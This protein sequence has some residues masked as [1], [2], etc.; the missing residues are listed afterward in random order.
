MGARLTFSEG[1]IERRER[2]INC[3]TSIHKDLFITRKN[4]NLLPFSE[5]IALLGIY[6]L[7]WELQSLFCALRTTRHGPTIS[8]RIY[9]RP[10]RGDFHNEFVNRHR[11]E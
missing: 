6:C 8:P 9:P 10:P 2:T 7:V 4:R 5:S 11:D 1:T 3:Q